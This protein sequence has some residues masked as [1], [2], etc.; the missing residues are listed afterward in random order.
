MICWHCYWGWPVPVMD[1]YKRSVAKLDGDWMAL[2]YGPAHVVW[3][4]ENFERNTVEWCLENCRTGK[5]CDGLT[6]WQVA[7]IAE[8]LEAL[9]ALPD[10]IR[11]SCPLAYEESDQKNPELF[12]PARNNPHVHTR[13]QGERINQAAPKTRIKPR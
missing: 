9:L 12:P 4:D 7:V 1:I 10:E 3:A 8:S 11:E 6:P 5:Y 13:D 2:D